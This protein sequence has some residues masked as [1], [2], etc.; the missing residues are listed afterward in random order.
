[1]PELNTPT[2][3][4]P[5]FLGDGKT[6]HLRYSLRTMQRLRKK[7][8]QSLLSKDALLA[9]DENTIPEL[10]YEGLVERADFPSSEEVADLITFQNLKYVIETFAEAW[11]GALPEKKEPSQPIQ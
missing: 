7:L 11:I 3:P 1:M 2:D 6:R 5:I 10:I 4:T 9:L 8:G